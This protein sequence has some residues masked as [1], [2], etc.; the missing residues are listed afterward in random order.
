MDYLDYIGTIVCIILIVSIVLLI[1]STVAKNDWRGWNRV[2]FVVLSIAG[3]L[4]VVGWVLKA[5]S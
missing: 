3:L 5:C 2:L 4:T 1:I